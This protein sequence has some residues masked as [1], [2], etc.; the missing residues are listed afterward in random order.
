V[1]VLYVGAHAHCMRPITLAPQT[2]VVGSTLE[3]LYVT[4]RAGLRGSSS[5]GV[6]PSGAHRANE[7]S[8]TDLRYSRMGTS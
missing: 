1:G 8:R 3:F 5:N 7:G 4:A 2:E 6:T